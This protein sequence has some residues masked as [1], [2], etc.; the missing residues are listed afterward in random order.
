MKLNRCLPILTA[1]LVAFALMSNPVY[2]LDNDARAV[3]AA[4]GRF[5]SALNILFTG[6][7][8]PMKELWSHAD[9]VTYMGPGGGYQI[10]WPRVSASWDRQAAMKLGGRVEPVQIQI[11]AGPEIA[12]VQNYEKGVNSNAA[13]QR[14][15]VLIRATSIF[16]MEQG[17][18]KMI[19]HHTDP[20]PYMKH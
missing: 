3:R 7:A 9:D 11:V 19:S 14:A 10:G 15:K 12:V 20:L 8:L 17:H 13:G 1:V 18:W 4:T 6:N 16:R 2:A 5:Y